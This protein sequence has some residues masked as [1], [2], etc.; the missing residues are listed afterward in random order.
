MTGED[1][2]KRVKF[3]KNMPKNYRPDVWTQEIAF[4]F[5][6]TAFTHKRNPMNQA[7]AP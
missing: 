1:R 3:G 6:G 7:R 2:A 4:Y 5:D